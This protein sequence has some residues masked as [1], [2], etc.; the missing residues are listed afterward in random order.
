MRPN[1]MKH[2]TLQMRINKKNVNLI[3]VKNV[4]KIDLAVGCYTLYKLRVT[5][6]SHL[7][8]IFPHHIQNGS[9]ISHLFFW[10]RNIK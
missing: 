9:E 5:L 2:D 10:C 1:E 3:V 8:L 7:L 4:I 6:F